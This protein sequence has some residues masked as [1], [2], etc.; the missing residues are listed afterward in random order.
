MVA[1]GRRSAEQSTIDIVPEEE[2]ICRRRVSSYSEY[3]NKVVELAMNIANYCDRCAYVHD[4]AL[5]HQHL[6]GLFTYFLEH[7]FMK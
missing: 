5:P 7:C 3:L 1:G 4:V 2:I 6:L